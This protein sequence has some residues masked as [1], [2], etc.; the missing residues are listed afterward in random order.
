M[1]L[2]LCW[3]TFPSDYEDMELDKLL[4]YQ[5]EDI[6]F[7]TRNYL[8]SDIQYKDYKIICGHT[9]VQ[10]IRNRIGDSTIIH[11]PGHIFIDCGCR[12]SDQQGC[13][14]KS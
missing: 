11:R 2:G 7:W 1:Q 5:K 12:I 8:N 13:V 10:T 14:E 9:P 6:N 4:E 3:F